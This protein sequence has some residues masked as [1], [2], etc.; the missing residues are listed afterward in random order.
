MLRKLL[1]LSLTILCLG[2][3]HAQPAPDFTVT[4]ANDVVRSLYADHLNQGQT[5]LIK[6]IFIGCPPCE[7][8]HDAIQDATTTETY[9]TTTT[10]T[11]QTTATDT[12]TT[13]PLMGRMLFTMHPRGR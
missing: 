10:T 1:T 11:T 12:S 9:G 3:I 7:A 13:S 5:V 2:S 6:L 4:D 8:Y